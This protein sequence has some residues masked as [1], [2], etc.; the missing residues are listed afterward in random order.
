MTSENIQDGGLVE[1]CNLGVLFLVNN[2]NNDTKDN[3]YG[4]DTTAEPLQQ[5]IH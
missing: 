1:V 3:V 4:D 2:N 5:S